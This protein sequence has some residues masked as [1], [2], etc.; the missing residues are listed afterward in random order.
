MA[1]LVKTPLVMPLELRNAWSGGLSTLVIVGA[2][3]SFGV[4]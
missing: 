1:D 4:V 3:P 2:G